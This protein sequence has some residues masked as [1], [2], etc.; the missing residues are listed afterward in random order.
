[1]EKFLKDV[2]TLKGPF[3][4][5]KKFL[6]KFYKVEDECMKYEFHF[7]HVQGS[8]DAM[9]ASLI[10][11]K[12]PNK[13]FG[14]DSSLLDDDLSLAI[15]DYIARL[16][17][18]AIEEK[19][20][21]ISG[22]GSSGSF[23]LLELGQEILFRN[24]VFIG[25]DIT[26]IWVRVSL[27]SIKKKFVDK[28]K[29]VEM[30][31]EELYEMVKYIKY[32]MVNDRN[33]LEL[34]KKTVKNFKNI[35]RKLKE[36]RLVAFVADGSVLPRRSGNSDL[37]LEGNDIK[38]FVSPPSLRVEFE[39]ENGEKIQG[40]GIPEGIVL[41]AGAG[42]HGKSTLLN[43][44]V[45]GVYPHIPGDGR[46]YV[47][48]R[49]DAVKI[50]AEDGR[51][52]NGVDISYFITSLPSKK[53]TNKFF[54]SLASGST[55]QAASFIEFINSGVRCFFIDEDDSATNFLM[56][57]ELMRSLLSVKSIIPLSDRIEELKSSG[58]NII[59]ICGG[60]SSY[61]KY[62]DVVIEMVNYIPYDITQK[63]KN[64]VSSLKLLEESDNEIDNSTVIFEDKRKIKVNS[65]DA[66]YFASRHN[67]KIK[68]R[69]KVLRGSLRSLEFGN[70]IVDLSALETIVEGYQ[71]EAIGW[72]L[73]YL[74]NN[75]WN[76][77]FVSF[78][79]IKETIDMV[80]QNKRLLRDVVIKEENS[81]LR[82]LS[83]PRKEDIIATINRFRN[84]KIK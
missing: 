56:Q 79:T 62:A 33:G 81:L 72:I 39:L 71:T 43:A 54:T 44:L 57:D 55:S 47:V 50:R 8:P 65:I 16:L 1:M 3:S 35:Q 64:L 31:E 10:E 66:D 5:Y 11:I 24:I 37:P 60:S 52:V 42:F 68:N 69:I 14:I 28:E 29:F 20:K 45:K 73:L 58:I 38:K 27:P 84:I 49:E 6:G 19:T 59:M 74:K 46:E 83:L 12:I 17:N 2:K 21:P 51:A 77:E 32:Y 26:S 15:T 70:E 80:F 23:Q 40:M 22:F 34:H 18:R 41:I 53:D 36:K 67:K 4:E 48:T 78:G 75:Y 30:I 61:L 7:L 76:G 13:E 25:K 9:P 82:Y 63:A